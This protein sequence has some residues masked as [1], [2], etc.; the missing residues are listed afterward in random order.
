MQIIFMIFNHS[1]SHHQ[2]DNNSMKDAQWLRKICVGRIL[3]GTEIID[4]AT[5]TTVCSDN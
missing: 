1:I 2:F 5:T 4:L 3:P